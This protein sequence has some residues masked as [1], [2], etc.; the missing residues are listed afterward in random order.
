MKHHR[1]RCKKRPQLQYHQ[2]SV[3]VVLRDHKYWARI[4]DEVDTWAEERIKRHGET[5]RKQAT[6]RQQN[7]IQLL[8]DDW[9]VAMSSVLSVLS[10]LR[11]C[12][13]VMDNKETA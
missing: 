2:K 13:D 5:T 1:I 7:E 8:V 9:Y 3:M 12:F 10:E 6:L 4:T 11:E